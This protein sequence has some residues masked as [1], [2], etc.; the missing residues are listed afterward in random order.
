MNM[1]SP[2]H[3][4]NVVIFLPVGEAKNFEC[5]GPI[6]LKEWM[7][8]GRVGSETRVFDRRAEA[9][10]T[11]GKYIKSCRERTQLQE[12]DD[13]DVTLTDLMGVAEELKRIS[14][15]MGGKA[16]HNDRQGNLGEHWQTERTDGNSNRNNEDN[17]LRVLSSNTGTYAH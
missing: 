3:P 17:H 1:K 6:Q 5:S 16:D 8:E 12:L 9:W 2:C 13:L 4:L 15:I 10:T 14:E 11:A 7:S